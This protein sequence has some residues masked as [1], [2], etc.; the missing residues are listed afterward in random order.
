MDHLPP[1]L[2]TKIV[3]ILVVTA[4]PDD[5]YYYPAERKIPDVAQELA[6][7]PKIAPLATLS[8]AWRSV[9]E[10]QLFHTLRITSE[11]WEAF[12]ENL[13]QNQRRQSM[14]SITLI[15]S[16]LGLSSGLGFG[17]S[18]KRSVP[19]HLQEYWQR[20]A[21]SVKGFY[22]ELGGRNQA[23]AV[24]SICLTFPTHPV[25]TA[26]SN[27]RNYFGA[28]ALRCGVPY[29][30][31]GECFPQGYR[32]PVLPTVQSVIHRGSDHRV[33]PVFFWMLA[34]ACL[35]LKSW[36][37]EAD[38]KERRHGDLVLEGREG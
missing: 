38:E 25:I 35:N 16:S 31:L 10:A 9:V 36:Y 20:L 19:N 27:D 6:Q 34:R 4:N 3:S 26:T 24:R 13:T 8:V 21:N 14:R 29:K 33:S 23:L 17:T 18:L 1:E 28:G 37:I 2:I 32:I 7:R 11:N 5:I 12:K 15:I 30:D 22:D